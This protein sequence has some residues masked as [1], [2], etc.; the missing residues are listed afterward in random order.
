MGHGPW[1]PVTTHNSPL[2]LWT[3]WPPDFLNPNL[4]TLP[5]LD[6]RQPNLLSP[7]PLRA[8]LGPGPWISPGPWGLGVMGYDCVIVILHAVLLR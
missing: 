5:P 1:T 8:F 2:E 4:W 3:P 6:P 7:P